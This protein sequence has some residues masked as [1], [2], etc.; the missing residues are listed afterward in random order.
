MA[1]ALDLVRLFAGATVLAFASYTDWKWRRAPNALWIAV[2]FVGLVLLAAEAAL[3]WSGT[4]ARWPYLAFVP[5][6]AAVVYGLWYLGLVAGGADAKALMALGVLAPFPVALGPGVPPLDSLVPGAFATLGNSLVFFLAIPLTLFA[7]NAARGDFRLPHAFL[8]VRRRGRDARRGHAWPM[9]TVDAEG[10]RA[11]RLFGS[12]MG[13]A[14]LDEQLDRIE[15][16]GDERVWVTPKVP[17][18]IP[19]LLGF[20]SSFLVGDLLTSAIQWAIPLPR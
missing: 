12:R 20:V 9:E 15:A 5:A 4:L 10:R 13:R 3:D 14:E 19:L 2:A 11:T 18:M 1:S 16:L 6:F 8:G 7:W 17:F